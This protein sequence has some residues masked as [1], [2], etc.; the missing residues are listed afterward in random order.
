MVTLLDAQ[1][2]VIRV[3]SY[4]IVPPLRILRRR[5]PE[6]HSISIKVDHETV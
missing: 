5:Y 2:R 3:I 6:A 1:G 4:L